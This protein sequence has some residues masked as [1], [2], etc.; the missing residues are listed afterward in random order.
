MVVQ[1]S[2]EQDVGDGRGRRR[3]GR[4]L[5]DACRGIKDN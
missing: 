4:I 1:A 3:Y 5:L 2:M